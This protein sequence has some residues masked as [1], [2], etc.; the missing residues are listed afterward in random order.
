MSEAKRDKLRRH[1][2]VFV[3]AVSDMRQAWAAAEYLHRA[4][5]NDYA[6]RAFWTGLVVTY[7]RPYLRSNRIGHV[8][9]K[10]ATPRDIELQPL[11]G[12]L[13]ARRN[14]LAAHNDATPFRGVID[15]SDFGMTQGR[16]HAEMYNDWD[17]SVL[18]DI[19]RLAHHQERRFTRKLDRIYKRLNP[20][21]S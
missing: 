14:D 2:D 8:K 13:M 15:L 17:P 12:F 10:L 7:A 18:P 16:T 1:R 21:D 5:M 4:T 11:H 3:L 19:A 9:G 6:G 20:P